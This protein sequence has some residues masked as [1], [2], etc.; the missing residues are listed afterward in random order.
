MLSEGQSYLRGAPWLMFAPGVAVFL[1]V[2]GFNLLGEGLREAL[3]HKER[4]G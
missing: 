3:D 4:R 1:A 2:L